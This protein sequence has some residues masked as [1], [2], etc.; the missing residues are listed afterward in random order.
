[1]SFR[2]EKKYRLTMSDQKILK[3]LLINKGLSELY[4]PRTINSCYLDNTAFECFYDSDEGSLPR[5]KIRLRWYDNDKELFKEVKFSSIE[6]RFKT[7]DKINNQ[8]FLFDFKYNF[9]DK[10][11]G[12]LSPVLIVRYIREYYLLKGVRI[13]FDSNISYTDL[14]G[15]FRRT[16]N[17][18]ETVMEIKS[19]NHISDDYLENLVNIPTTRFSKYCRGILLIDNMA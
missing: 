9:F 6:G 7:S 18:P 16:L 17:D 1:M 12:L 3:T 15:S 5:K 13:T 2:L 8:T 4:P 19:P 10:D 14:R 11:Y